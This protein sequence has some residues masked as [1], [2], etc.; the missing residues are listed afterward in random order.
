MYE[1]QISLIGKESQKILSKKTIAI[2]GLGALGSNSANLLARA[3]INLKLIDFDTIDETNLLSQSL[4]SYSDLKKSKAETAF[5]KLKE[6]NPLIKIEFINALIDDSNLSLLNSD[7]VLDCTDNISTRLLINEYCYKNKIP[8]VHS[9][10]LGYKGVIYNSL[11]SQPCL[12]CIYKS[13][14]DEEKCEDF[15][16]LNTIVSLISS[17]S[18][19]EAIKILLKENYEKSLLRINIKDNSIAKINVKKD[20]NCICC[21]IGKSLD[22][23]KYRLCKNESSFSITPLKNTKIDEEK[24]RKSFKI[25]EVTNNSIIASYKN[26]DL[27]IYKNGKIIGNNFNKSIIS[28]IYEDG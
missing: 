15:G 10:V 2:L 3:G 1:R 24:I 20:R 13:F 4:Y 21:G 5:K 26:N 22:F 28:L 9:A 19:N 25:K 14:S 23:K 17:I 11:N 12:S 27:I 8:L 18:S 16:V 7:L 6:I